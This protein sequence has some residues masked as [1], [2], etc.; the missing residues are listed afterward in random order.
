[1]VAGAVLRR[2]PFTFDFCAR[3]RRRLL[4]YGSFSGEVR[5]LSSPSCPAIDASG[6]L[7]WTALQLPPVGASF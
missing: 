3:N 2:A 6:G 5:S 4:K 7:F 1:M